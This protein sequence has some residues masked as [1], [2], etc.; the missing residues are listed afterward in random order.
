MRRFVFLFA[1]LVAASFGVSASAAPHGWSVVLNES[2]PV[3]GSQV[4][5]AVSYR[6][7]PY[8]GAVV[9]LRC[10]QAGVVVLNDRRQVGFDGL[11]PIEPAPLFTLAFAGAASCVAELGYY[12]T[13][14]GRFAVKASTSFGVAAP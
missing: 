13:P 1:V 3:A 6:G 12:A 2:D 8:A 5:F 10:S 9:R 11:P 7:L 14:G 4:S